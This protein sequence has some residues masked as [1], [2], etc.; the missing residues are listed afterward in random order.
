[1]K[2]RE[3]ILQKAA[4]ELTEKVMI[5]QEDNENMKKELRKYKEVENDAKSI[6]VTDVPLKEFD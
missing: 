5:L 1:M 2:K 6:K 4:A 3:T